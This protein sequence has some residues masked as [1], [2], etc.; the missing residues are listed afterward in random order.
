MTLL[1]SC[2]IWG[3]GGALLAATAIDT[4]AV[5]GRQLGMPVRGS[6]ELIQ[7][8][9]LVAGGIAL[10][11]ATLADR[12]ARVRLM[13]DRLGGWRRAGAERASDLLTALFFACLLGGSGWLA[14]DLWAAH[15]MSELVGVPW[16]WLRLFANLCLAA[17]TLLALRQALRGRGR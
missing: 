9:V 8:A 13:V 1:R 12:H 11:V 17:V 15:E 5:V 10:V 6:I 16:R 2:L 3:G 14:L 4:L 7:A